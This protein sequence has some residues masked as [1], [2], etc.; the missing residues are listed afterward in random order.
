MSTDVINAE[1]NTDRLRNNLTTIGNI[2][3]GIKLAIR[4]KDVEVSDEEP[5]TNYANKILQIQVG[6]DTS[7]ATA[8]AVDIAQGK[9]AYVDGVKITGSATEVTSGM[10]F[11]AVS[12]DTT[13]NNVQFNGQTG[14]NLH[15][16]PNSYARVSAPQSDVATA[17]GLTADKIAEGETILGITGTF[18]GGEDLEAL[19]SLQEQIILGL[20]SDLGL[21]NFF[22]FSSVSTFKTSATAASYTRNDNINVEIAKSSFSA[23]QVTQIES[24]QSGDYFVMLSSDDAKIIVKASA[25]VTTSGSNYVFSNLKFYNTYTE[26]SNNN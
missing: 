6:I 4:S 9:T 19:V 14:T 12:I 22:D 18:K 21:M 11:P 15:F 13:N 17:I 25:A 24:I 23:Q 3:S 20:K 5:F 1:N 7:D 10:T 2:K 16:R 26:P 8:A